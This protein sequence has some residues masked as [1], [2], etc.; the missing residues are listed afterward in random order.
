MIQGEKSS[1]MLSTVLIK[2]GELYSPS[3]QGKKDVLVINGKI[4]L[5]EN[6]LC[7]DYI[8]RVFPELKVINA[9]GLIVAPGIIDQH[10]HFAGAGGEGGEEF[11]TP[12]APITSFLEAGITTAIGLLGTDGVGRTLEELLAKARSLEKEGISTYIYTGSYQFPSPTLTGDV[13]RDLYFFREIIGVKMALADHRSSY[14]SPFEIRR[15]LTKV[16]VGAMLAGKKGLVCVHMGSGDDMLTPLRD[17]IGGTDIPITHIIP[18]HVGRTRELLLDTSRWVKEGGYADLTAEEDLSE[19]LEFLKKQGASIERLTVSSDGN[20]SLPEFDEKKQL[21]GMSIG[22]PKSIIKSLKRAKKE[23][24]VSVEEAF[25]LVTS[26][27]ADL[28][29]LKHKGRITPGCDADILVLEE[30][31]FNILALIAKGKVLVENGVMLYKGMFGGMPK[32]I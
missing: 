22:K 16:R 9:K 2:E 24:V 20:G 29:G 17:A 11:R 32:D 19:H 5:V 15:L 27:V 23:G 28:L 14:P 7:V 8:K 3:Y 10:N 31:S 18:T 25:K 12:P 21:V 13:M 26:N 1:E 4:H 30:E 6:D